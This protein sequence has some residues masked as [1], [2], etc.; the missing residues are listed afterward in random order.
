M[1]SAIESS[2]NSSLL[3]LPNLNSIRFIAALL[4]IFSH[5][6]LYREF[7]GQESLIAIMGI[8]AGFGVDVFFALSGF[9]I[10]Y[11][12]IIENKKCGKIHIGHFYVRRTL[13]IWPAYYI[14]IT[15]VRISKLVFY[16]NT[17][18]HRKHFA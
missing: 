7:M 13:R 4:V 6:E 17:S 14:H 16:L 8:F 12:L 3:H 2:Q 9:L 10:T 11:L 1:K 15:I 18:V 5:I